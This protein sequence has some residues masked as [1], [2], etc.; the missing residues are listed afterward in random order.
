MS[1]C[2]ENYKEHFWTL[3][4]EGE[5]ASRAF[6]MPLIFVHSTF[7]SYQQQN[8]CVYVCIRVEREIWSFK[9]NQNFEWSPAMSCNKS[10]NFSGPTQKSFVALVNIQHR[11]YWL[12]GSFPRDPGSFH[13][14]AP[15]TS[16]RASG[17]SAFSQ[18]MKKM[19]GKRRHTPATS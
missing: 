10:P 3:S 13:I 1:N 16:S 17:S 15:S 9:R 2:F 4:R 8:M 5:G 18:Q 12:V 11:Y 19:K 7:T 6:F 14:V